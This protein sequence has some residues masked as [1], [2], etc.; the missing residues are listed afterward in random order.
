MRVKATQLG[1]YD[2]KRRK[3]DE[4]FMLK[5]V[6]KRV[7]KDG[8]PVIEGGRFKYEVAKTP[9]QQFSA[10]WMEALDEKPKQSGKKGKPSQDEEIALAEAIE[11]EEA[12]DEP[13]VDQKAASGD[14]L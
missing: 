10:K 9:E 13:E 1:Y 3:V 6:L 5:P 14:V 11:A 4:V 12:I 7:M 8:K 2:H